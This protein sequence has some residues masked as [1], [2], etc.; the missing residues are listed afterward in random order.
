MPL[1]TKKIN[2]K[3]KFD[4]QTIKY[5]LYSKE[6]AVEK[7][8]R[9]D[10]WKKIRNEDLPCY[11][12]DDDGIVGYIWERKMLGK[13]NVMYYASPWGNFTFAP[14][15]KSKVKIHFLRENKSFDEV[16][17]VLGGRKNSFAVKKTLAGYIARGLSFKEASH[18]LNLDVC[19]ESAINKWTRTMEFEKMITNEIEQV[20]KAAGIEKDTVIQKYLEAYETAKAKKDGKTMAEITDRMAA[21]LKMNVKFVGKQT[22]KETI[23]LS[24]ASGDLNKIQ[25]KG[26]KI[27]SKSLT[28]TAG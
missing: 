4:G 15:T 6:E 19:K 13:G 8:I 23:D 28:A 26:K 17:S 9:F 1:A 22:I 25:S 5:Y 21:L 20:L 18:L 2:H 16:K 14:G 11:V 24:E 10:Y 3:T 27:E 7:G 12:M